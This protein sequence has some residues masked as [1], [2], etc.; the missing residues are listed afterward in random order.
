MAKKGKKFKGFFVILGLG[1]IL[2]FILLSVLATQKAQTSQSHAAL[3]P[4][5]AC[6]RKCLNKRFLSRAC[7]IGPDCDQLNR[8]NDE[9]FGYCAKSCGSTAPPPPLNCKVNANCPSGKACSPSSHLCYQPPGSVP[10]GKTVTGSGRAVPIDK[11]KSN[12]SRQISN[13]NTNSSTIWQI[14]TTSGKK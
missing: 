10:I 12:A 1:I 3:P 6:L 14:I 11:G 4:F 2:V 8:Y 9:I 5:G 13:L 7:Q